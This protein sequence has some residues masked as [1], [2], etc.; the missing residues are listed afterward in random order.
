MRDASPISLLVTREP[1]SSNFTDCAICLYGGIRSG[2]RFPKTQIIALVNQ[3][4][5]CGKTTSAVALAA[6]FCNLG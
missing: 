6:G 1:E 4:G 3:K 2:V 5:G